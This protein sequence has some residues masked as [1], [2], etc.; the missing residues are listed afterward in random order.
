MKIFSVLS[1]LVTTLSAT[2]RT[3]ALSWNNSGPQ[4]DNNEVVWERDISG[5]CSVKDKGR[6][7]ITDGSTAYTIQNL[8]EDS[9]YTVIVKATNAAGSVASDAVVTNTLTA[10]EKI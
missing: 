6:A 1:P 7:T 5:V 3:I 8:Q 2:S 10:G 4:I 9:S